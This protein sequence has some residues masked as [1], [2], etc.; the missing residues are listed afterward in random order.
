VL[1]LLLLLLSF[2]EQEQEHATGPVTPKGF[3]EAERVL[4][5]AEQLL[6]RYASMQSERPVT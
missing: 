2:A 1:C 6:A 4:S 5:F 3:S